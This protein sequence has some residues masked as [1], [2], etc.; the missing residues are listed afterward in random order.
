MSNKRYTKE[1]YEQAKQ[2]NLVDF[3]SSQGF[4]FTQQGKYFKC[5]EHDSL[6]VLTTGGWFWNSK[7]IQ[8]YNT[9]GFLVK[10]NGLSPYEA[11]TSLCDSSTEI[12]VIPKKAKTN[13][14]FFIPE[15]AKNYKRVFAYLNKTRCIDGA[16][17]S[18]LMREHKIYETADYHNCA[19]IGFDENKIPRNI[20]LRGTGKKE[21]KGD[22][23]SS[24]KSYGFHISGESDIV[25]VFES[26]IDAMSQ[27][28]ISKKA[29][30]E[31]TA[32]HRLSLGCTWDGA[33]ERFLANYDINIIIFCL[34][35]DKAGHSACEEYMK[36]YRELGYDVE[37]I[38]PKNKDFNSDLIEATEESLTSQQNLKGD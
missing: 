5:K 29:G 25:F 17:I 21:F 32:H 15:E 11:I 34:D 22:V 16:I 28:T 2:I 23:P 9:V 8:G 12:E 37:R 1:Q 19:F 7:G 38:V 26:P 30:Y 3:L 18:L 33:L 10:A 36:K 13:K 35:N 6:I 20:L 14:P 4:S 27:A 31:Y 24:D